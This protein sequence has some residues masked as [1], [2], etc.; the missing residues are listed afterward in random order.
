MI[1][2]KYLT[3]NK[4]PLD[5]ILLDADKAILINENKGAN[6]SYLCLLKEL[7]VYPTR[8]RDLLRGW[9]GIILVKVD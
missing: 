3:K 1:T 8:V 6:Y 4:F 7:F 5:Y 2:I 9:S